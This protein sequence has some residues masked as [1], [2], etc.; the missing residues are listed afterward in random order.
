MTKLLLSAALLLTACLDDATSE[1][2]TIHID[3]NVVA[4]GLTSELV[5][6]CETVVETEGACAVACD[7]EAVMELIPPGT[8]ILF[9]CTREDGGIVNL[10][11]CKSAATT[12]GLAS[13]PF[14]ARSR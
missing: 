5:E 10:G 1:P 7:P 11:G 8:C 4:A 3:E 12:R 6:L 9:V 2:N 13:S 14:D